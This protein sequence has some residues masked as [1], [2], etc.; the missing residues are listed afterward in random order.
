MTFGFEVLKLPWDQ[1]TNRKSKVF[2][3]IRKI[4]IPRRKESI[5]EAIAFETGE[6]QEARKIT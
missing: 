5:E 3:H 1:E 4:S 6:S 2:P